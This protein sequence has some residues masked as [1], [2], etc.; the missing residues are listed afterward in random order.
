LIDF[1]FI[2]LTYTHPHTLWQS[3]RNIRAA[4]L[5]RR[6]EFLHWQK[7]PASV[8]SILVQKTNV[9]HTHAVFVSPVLEVTLLMVG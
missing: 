6:R 4:V 9:Q 3:D 5:R 2:V 1:R 8:R 7:M